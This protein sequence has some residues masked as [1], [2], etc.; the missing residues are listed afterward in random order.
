MERVIFDYSKLQGRIK[1]KLGTQR[2][3]AKALGISEGSMVS[4]L[5]CDTY[6]TQREIER[7]KEILGIDPGKI[8]VYFFTEKV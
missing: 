4:K 3:F 6:F 5:K 2:E 1:E 7:S 8:S